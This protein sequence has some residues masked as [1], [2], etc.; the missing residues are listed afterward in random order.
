MSSALMS[1]SGIMCGWGQPIDKYPNQGAVESER[2]T[3]KNYARV[4]PK[5]GH[6][7]TLCKSCALTAKEA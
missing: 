3:I 5:P 2:V 6:M 4:K 1:E 7:A